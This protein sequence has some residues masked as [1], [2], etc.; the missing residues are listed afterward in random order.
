MDAGWLSE[1][2]SL[3]PS[4]FLTFALNPQKRLDGFLSNLRTNLSHQA[5]RPAIFCAKVL[6]A[7]SKITRLIKK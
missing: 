7:V 2:N 1:K 5:L 6:L 4:I 3:R